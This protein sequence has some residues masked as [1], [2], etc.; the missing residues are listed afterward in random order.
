MEPNDS[1]LK[2][3]DVSF[4]DALNAQCGRLRRTPVQAAAA[5]GHLYVVRNLLGKGANP[6]VKSAKGADQN[7]KS[8]KECEAGS[9]LIAAAKGGYKDIV[10]LLLQNGAEINA[11]SADGSRG[12]AVCEAA[13][14]GEVEVV[15]LLISAGARDVDAA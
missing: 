14:R 12:H 5:C 9:P 10:D 2:A 13:R 4:R 7:I 11:T 3:L 15:K 1:T 8:A 6:N